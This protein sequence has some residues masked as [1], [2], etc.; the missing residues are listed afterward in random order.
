MFPILAADQ[1]ADGTSLPAFLVARDGVY[2]RKRTLLGESQTKVDRLAHLP[3]AQEYVEY[4]LPK[5]PADLMG[6]VVGFF[7]AVYRAQRTEALVLLTWEAGRFALHVPRQRVS[8]SSVKFTLADDEL[9]AGSRL[10]GTIHSHGAF[11]AFASSIDEA[12]E[13]ELDGLHLVIGDLDRR[14]PSY[15]AAIAIDGQRFTVGLR[16]VLERPRRFVEPPADWL[17]RVKLLPPP[18]PRKRQG[19]LDRRADR[20]APGA[21]LGSSDSGQS[22]RV[23]RPHREGQPHGGRPR[24]SPR[25]LAHPGVYTA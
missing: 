21:W 8:G 13:A 22:E 23:R 4:T 5:I 14:A 25:L 7:R 17:G 18:R 9:P 16:L 6:R 19:W 24:L 11:G 15:S 1:A 2:L 3:T 20:L 12:D 10:V